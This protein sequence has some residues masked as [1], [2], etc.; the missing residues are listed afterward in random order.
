[1][2][3][4]ADDALDVGGE[5]AVEDAAGVGAAALPVPPQEEARVFCRL[6][7]SLQMAAASKYRPITTNKPL[8]RFKRC[9]HWGS[10]LV[11]HDATPIVQSVGC[12]MLTLQIQGLQCPAAC[13]CRAAAASVAACSSAACPSGTL[14]SAVCA[15]AAAA[16]GPGT[17]ACDQRSHVELCSWS[18]GS[19]DWNT[20]GR[21]NALAHL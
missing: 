19:W 1:M 9:H 5:D 18:Y 17:A 21:T 14:P 7:K 13:T 8:L 2:H 15:A 16:S 12:S 20:Q 11:T 10:C 6:R 3:L 4:H